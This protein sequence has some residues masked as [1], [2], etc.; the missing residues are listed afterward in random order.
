MGTGKF[1]ARSPCASRNQL[2]L[3]QG[4]CRSQGHS[5]WESQDCSGSGTGENFC[6]TNFNL[7]YRVTGRSIEGQ[8][9]VDHPRVLHPPEP[10]PVIRN[11]L[12]GGLTVSHQSGDGLV[13]PCP[14]LP[15]VGHAGAEVM[16]E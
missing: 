2:W 15:V 9:I 8:F 4:R 1:Q 7:S 13:F 11:T 16:E 5:F 10:A 12:A 3:V 6:S 14:V